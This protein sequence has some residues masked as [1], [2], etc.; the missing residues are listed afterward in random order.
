MP[1]PKKPI[2]K[3]L[4]PKPTRL[5]KK[6]D[7]LDKRTEINNAKAKFYSEKWEGNSPRTM[8]EK[9]NDL[10]LKKRDKFAEKTSALN[11]KAY[12]TRQKAEGKV[13]MNKGK[14]QMKNEIK[15]VKAKY[16]KKK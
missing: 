6:A 4:E 10:I 13:S 5:V 12:L 8:T 2:K 3:G 16:S 9:Q 15:A 7:R 14:D 11:Q 1:T